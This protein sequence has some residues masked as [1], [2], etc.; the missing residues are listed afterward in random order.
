MVGGEDQVDNA[1]EL[2]V[3]GEKCNEDE[4]DCGGDCI[5]NPLKGR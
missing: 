3:V 5:K 2:M 4:L 1:L